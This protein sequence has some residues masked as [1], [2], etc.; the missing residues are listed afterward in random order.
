MEVTF[1]SLPW[2]NDR[3]A[4]SHTYWLKKAVSPIIL[5]SLQEFSMYTNINAAL[6]FAPIFHELNLRL[7]DYFYA[8][9][10][11]ISV[12]SEEHLCNNHAV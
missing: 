9:K 12:Q 10:R 11:H 6:V 5:H 7:K 3:N 2:K 8:H 4:T 1:R